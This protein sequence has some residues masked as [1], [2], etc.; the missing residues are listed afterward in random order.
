MFVAAST[1]CFSDKS[2]SEAC[3]LLVDL[4]YDKIEI[5]FD[6][7]TDHLK[8]SEVTSDL[9]AFHSAFRKMTRLTPVAFCLEHDIDADTL[10][11][12]SKLAKVMKVTQITIP[13]S[14]I[15]TPFNAEIDRLREFTGIASQDGVR[16]SIKTRTGQLTEDAHTAVELCQ[17]VKGLGLTLDPSYYICGPNRGAAYDQVYP[18]VYH[19]HLRDTSPEQLQIQV[20]LGDI[21]YSRL[22]SQLGRENYAR[23][24]SVEFLPELLDPE[25][26][27]LEMRKL[28]MLLET[29]L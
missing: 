17:A 25:I 4:E 7:S 21:D 26:R 27:P 23:A 6:E 12:L 5:W 14:P 3:Q 10:I 1:R 15:G 22:I 18:Y 8:P 11:G 9:E 24:L 13:S 16:L 19:T 28:R 20:G 29:L 2:F